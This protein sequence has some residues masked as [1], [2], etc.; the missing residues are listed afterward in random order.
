MASILKVDA[1]QGVT[2]AGSILV[3]GEGNSTTTNLQSGLMKAWVRY[4]HTVPS[5]TDSFNESSVTDISTGV[6]SLQFTNNMSNGNYGWNNGLQ[7]GR[8]DGVN[9]GT[10]PASGTIR[11]YQR[12]ANTLAVNDGHFTLASI[13]GDLA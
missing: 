10:V 6:W 13:H 9:T 12:V 11:Y 4:D 8:V 7:D 3:T 2:A 1:L 5:V